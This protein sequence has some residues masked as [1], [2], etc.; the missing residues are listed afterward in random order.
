MRDF[1]SGPKP[2][3]WETLDSDSTPL[4]ITNKTALLLITT[5]ATV[6][7]LWPILLSQTQS[8]GLQFLRLILLV[9]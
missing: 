9:L 7:N 1:D 3:L 8:E 4:S 6:T 5:A 2:G